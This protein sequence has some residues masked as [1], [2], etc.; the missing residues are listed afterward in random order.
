MGGKLVF[1]VLSGVRKGWGLQG[2]CASIPL[3][4]ITTAGGVGGGLERP[5]FDKNRFVV[6]KSTLKITQEKISSYQRS[7][8]SFPDSER[9]RKIQ[10]S[11]APQPHGFVTF[12]PR[13]QKVTEE[14]RSRD[15]PSLENSSL[16]QRLCHRGGWHNVVRTSTTP[17]TPPLRPTA[18]GLRLIGC[19]SPPN[20]VGLGW[21]LG[22]RGMFLADRGEFS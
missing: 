18:T 14:R 10:P 3:A 2:G 13:R 7:T 20:L 16:N 17:S 11:P 22:C 21:G 19:P 15:V 8:K 6:D 4:T 9:T 5:D 12:C 1:S